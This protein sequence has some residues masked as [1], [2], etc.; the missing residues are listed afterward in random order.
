[1]VSIKEAVVRELRNP[2][3]YQKEI[4][5]YVE[6]NIADAF[7]ICC[8]KNLSINEKYPDSKYVGQLG[9]KTVFITVRMFDLWETAVIDVLSEHM[10]GKF[11]KVK[12]FSV[13]DPIGDMAIAFPDNEILRWEIKS[14]QAENSFTGATHSASKCD[15]YVLINYSIDRNLKLKQ[16]EKNT[17]FITELAVLVWDNMDAKWLGEPSE[18]SS[19]T[20]LKLPAEICEKRPE[21]MVVGRLEAKQKWCDII[22][23]KFV[24]AFVRK[25]V[26]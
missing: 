14:S 26:F 20:S 17:G 8:R 5:G 23:K 18:H 16:N 1:M 4:V 24:N 13:N 10:N 15:N 25:D 12:I 21:I 6:E 9:Q 7:N 22:R 19:F 2:D 11:P 3:L